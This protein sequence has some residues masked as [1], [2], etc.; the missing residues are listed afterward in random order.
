MGVTAIDLKGS[1]CICASLKKLKGLIKQ[2]GLV[3]CRSSYAS[4]MN[5]GR[6][7]GAKQSEMDDGGKEIVIRKRESG[8]REKIQK[9]EH[10]RHRRRALQN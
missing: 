1:S 5:R 9:E 4:E 3:Q 2:R 7:E 6:R 10:R 8:E